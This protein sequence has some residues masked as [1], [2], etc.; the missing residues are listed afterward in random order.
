MGDFA[1]ADPDFPFTSLSI[2]TIK[3]EDA[4]NTKQE[5]S[6]EMFAALTGPFDL[7]LLQR[8]RDGSPSPV[9]KGVDSYGW[10]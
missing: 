1:D 3:T 7:S 5:T 4:L 6:D 9:L 10:G 2:L 8:S